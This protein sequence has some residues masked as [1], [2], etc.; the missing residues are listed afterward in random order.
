MVLPPEEK[1]QG[2]LAAERYATRR[3]GSEAAAGRDPRRVARLLARHGILPS[4]SV[5]DV[6]CGTGRLR[7][8][9]EGL[10]LRVTG[11]DISPAMLAAA[12][13]ER[14][15]VGAAERLPFGDGSF[16]A[17]VCCRLLHH[18]STDDALAATIAEFAR[19]SRGLV[20]ASFWDANSW[21]GWRRALGLR[22]D[23]SGRRALSL[24]HLAQLFEDAGAPIIDTAHSLRFV[25]MQA[26]VV[27]RVRA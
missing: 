11:V 24:R 19:V 5:L 21:H 20:V 6:P 17:V 26:F 23:P 12:P 27:A 16:D 9:L 15:L 10:G 13:A 18:L 3:F 8:S 25:S 7:P 4:Q 2:E 22:E 1:W 14:S